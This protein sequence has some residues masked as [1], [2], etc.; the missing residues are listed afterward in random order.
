[1]RDRETA[2]FTGSPQTEEIK[3]QEMSDVGLDLCCDPS[4]N[5]PT[6]NSSAMKLPRVVFRFD[7][8]MSGACIHYG[9]A[10]VSGRNSEKCTHC[11]I[12]CIK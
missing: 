4:P 10:L 5:P 6:D 2:R 11:S 1:M 12:Y 9:Q 7:K 3:V 8:V